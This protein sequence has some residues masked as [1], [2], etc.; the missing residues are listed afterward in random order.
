MRRVGGMRMRKRAEMRTSDTQLDTENGH[1]DN[2][3]KVQRVRKESFFPVSKRYSSRINKVPPSCLKRLIT[4][5]E[6]LQR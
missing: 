2:I 4:S 6:L 1:Y 5:I 3:D